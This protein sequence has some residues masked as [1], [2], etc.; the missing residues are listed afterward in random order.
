MSFISGRL[1]GIWISGISISGIFISGISISGISLSTGTSAP[2]SIE[3]GISLLIPTSAISIFICSVLISE[4]TDIDD[5]KFA[6]CIS[7]GGFMSIMPL[8]SVSTI[9]FSSKPPIITSGTITIATGVSM[10]VI[11][12]TSIGWATTTSANVNVRLKSSIIEPNWPAL[13]PV[14]APKTLTSTNVSFMWK[15][16]SKSIVNVDVIVP[17]L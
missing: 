16:L 14:S 12:I 2:T 7:S 5:V 17:S 3:V 15:S 13:L 4:I 10:G 8:E 6:I 1:S 9:E 11:S